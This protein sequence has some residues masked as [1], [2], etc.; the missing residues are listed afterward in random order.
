MS[1][2][3]RPRANGRRSAYR[4]MSEINVTPLVDVMLVLLIVFMISAPLLAT[5]LPVDLPQAKAPALNEQK[6]SVTITVR[7][8]GKVFLSNDDREIS[9]ESL[10]PRLQAVLKANPNANVYL[11]GDQAITYGRFIQVMALLNNAGFQKVGLPFDA[12]SASRDRNA[13]KS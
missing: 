5:G 9:D 12:P 11:R 10:V 7:S 8:D 2:P 6:D 1:G 4:P 13:R 3:A